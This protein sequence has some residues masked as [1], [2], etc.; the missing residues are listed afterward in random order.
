M[1]TIWNWLKKLGRALSEIL[2]VWGRRLTFLLFALG[3]ILVFFVSFS[4]DGTQPS[5]L[6]K[7]WS[8]AKNGFVQMTAR[9]WAWATDRRV[10][11]ILPNQ[12]LSGFLYIEAPQLYTRERLVNDRFR[13]ANWLSEELKRTRNPTASLNFSSPSRVAREVQRSRLT[14]QLGEGEI[15]SSET[16]GSEEEAKKPAPELDQLKLLERRLNYRAE[17][18]NELMDTQLDDGHD[19]DGNTLYRLNFDAIAMPW[20]D[21]HSYPGAALFIVTAKQPDWPH[22]PAVTEADSNLKQLV[23]DDLE[24]LRS[25]K[26]KMQIFLPRV[27]QHR[28]TTFSRHG[29]LQ[30]QTD[31]KEDI[32]FDWFL[33]V[34]L[35]ESFLDLLVNRIK[36]DFDCSQNC[37]S[38]TLEFKKEWEA[39]VKAKNGDWKPRRDR[40]AEWTGFNY[41]SDERSPEISDALLEKRLHHAIRHARQINNWRLRQGKTE[42]EFRTR[43]KTDAKNETGKDPT[44]E[45][46]AGNLL[47]PN[48]LRAIARLIKVVDALA[49]FLKEKKIKFSVKFDRLGV[50]G[51]PSELDELIAQFN[52]VVPTQ[53][54]T[55]K[56]TK[57]WRD[58]KTPEDLRRSW[59]EA[60]VV[61]KNEPFSYGKCMFFNSSAGALADEMIAQF[62]EARLHGHLPSYKKSERPIGK[63]L[64]IS[65]AGCGLTG[66]RFEVQNREKLTD[67]EV[68]ALKEYEERKESL[69]LTHSGADEKDSDPDLE[70]E[71]TYMEQCAGRVSR[72]VQKYSLEYRVKDTDKGNDSLSNLLDKKKQKALKEL[73]SEI[74][75]L[76]SAC[77]LSAW[78]ESRRSDLV[79]YGVSP[80][81]G[82]VVSSHGS[83][84]RWELATRGESKLPTAMSARIGRQS[85]RQLDET[86][87]TPLVI[88]FSQITQKEGSRAKP[89][90]EAVFGWVVR[91]TQSTD[92]TWKAGHHRL[93]AVVSVPSWW[94]RLEFE[95]T[96][97]WTSP[98]YGRELGQVILTDPKAICSNLA[99]SSK[100]GNSEVNEEEASRTKKS[101]RTS[102]LNRDFR[103]QLPR[104][105]EDVMSRFSFEFIKT[106]YFDSHLKEKHSSGK[107]IKLEVG[108]KGR[109]VLSGERLWRGTVVTLGEQPADNIVVL[110]DMKGVIAEFN[111]VNPPPG[112]DH[113][114]RFEAL[115]NKSSSLADAKS[116]NADITVWTSEGRTS[117]GVY[118]ELRPFVQRI[119]DEKPCFALN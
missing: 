87:V 5:G 57:K 75:E 107:P 6:D 95:V 77:M 60:C 45:E 34:T 10:E 15:R 104:R 72:Y 105:V 24:L 67:D 74:I 41:Q 13:Q 80:R 42:E 44:P 111:C 108:R 30:N 99:G 93:A 46:C 83:E 91:S 61:Y 97:C 19:L 94:K 102:S 78:L 85:E 51:G 11:G 96:A 38:E 53:E 101:Q 89:A 2:D 109:V 56:K 25:W 21:S 50:R 47:D 14:V 112:E 35:I 100:I 63:F 69:H 52:N 59:E 36:L 12:T 65:L 28:T 79:V 92:G 55:R 32:A 66:C 62:I 73:R 9:S 81:T 49:A 76:F 40:L 68:T 29:A 64:K 20:A 22:D 39:N 18:R 31:P 4:Y 88:G 43:C 98:S 54:E 82:G 86:T 16:S 103:I 114:K 117:E 8:M 106:P 115:T 1:K 119:R 26:R 70:S 116:G 110:P 23:E 58:E 7:V 48:N 90:D 71:R 33:R 27:L 84:R 118:A 17:L 3:A 113:M 37:D